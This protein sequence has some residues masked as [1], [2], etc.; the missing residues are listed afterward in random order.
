[1]LMI[2]LWPERGTALLRGGEAGDEELGWLVAFTNATFP[3]I[4]VAGLAAVTSVFVRFHRAR[5]E[6]R[7]QI[8]WFA[9]AAAVMLVWFFVFEGLVNAEGGLLEAISAISSL[10]LVPAIPRRHRHSHIQIPALRH[11]PDRQPY[12]SLRR[13]YALSGAG[14]LRERGLLAVRLARSH[15][16]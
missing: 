1:M 2:L 11:R 10:L 5:G 4:L 6:E 13:S 9:F 16:R 15:R 14:L 8:K 7:Q 3:L 12:P